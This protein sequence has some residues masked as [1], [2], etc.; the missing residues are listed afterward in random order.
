MRYHLTFVRMAVIKKTTNNK[1]WQDVEKREHLCIVGNALINWCI[2]KENIIVVLQKIKNK[3]T[4][5]LS[6]S[7]PE[8]LSKE[9]K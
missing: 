7:F 4:K 2:H 6:S 8:Y 1:C 3:T 5:Q 9:R